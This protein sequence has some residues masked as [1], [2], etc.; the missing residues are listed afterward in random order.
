MQ[1]IMLRSKIHRAVVTGADLDYEGSIGIS[2]ELIGAAGLL[3]FEKVEIYNINNGSR[4]ATY[5]IEGESGEVTLNGAAA[6]H[7][8]PGDRIIIAAYCHC[9]EEE[10]RTVEPTVVLVGGSNRDFREKT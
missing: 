4:I 1:R 6:R 2:P 10:A 3:P 8:Q 9:S 7:A 5:V